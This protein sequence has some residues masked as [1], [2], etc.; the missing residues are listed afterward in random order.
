M[1]Q[2]HKYGKDKFYYKVQ[3]NYKGKSIAYPL[4]RFI[5]VWFYEDIPDGDFVVDHI[6]N[7][8]LNNKLENLQLLTIEENNRKRFEDLDIKCIN[9]YHNTT[10]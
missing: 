7:D 9:Q 1:V 5:Y 10:R 8:P 4:G 3:F 2:R 6:D